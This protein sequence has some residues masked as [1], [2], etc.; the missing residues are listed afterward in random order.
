MFSDDGYSEEDLNIE[1]IDVNGVKSGC[2]SV[3]LRKSGVQPLR[4][5]HSFSD[6][7]LGDDVI[8]HGVYNKL[9]KKIFMQY[10]NMYM[11][12]TA[13]PNNVVTIE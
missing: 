6:V 1:R 4:V 2:V 5:K 13:E 8:M 3:T 12:K 9:I 7:S 11:P 10:L